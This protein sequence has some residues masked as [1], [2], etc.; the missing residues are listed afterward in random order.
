MKRSILGLFKRSKT[1]EWPY[2]DIKSGKMTYGQRLDLGGLFKDTTMT[3]MEQF[4]A[5]FKCLYNRVPKVTDY[6][7]LITKYEEI[8][9][10]I[11]FWAEKEAVMLKYDPTPEEKRAGIKELCDKV[12]DMGTLK[13]LAKAYSKD[14]DEILLWEYGKVFGILY[15]DLEESKYRNRYQEIINKK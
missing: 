8:L 10:G 12:G 9:A 14:P 7:F 11:I 4:D 13:A 2:I 3:E 15:T 1:I 6:P 5:V